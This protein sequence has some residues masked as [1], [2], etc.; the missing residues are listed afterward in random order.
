MRF[1]PS[2]A[3]PNEIYKFAEVYKSAIPPQFKSTIYLLPFLGNP[4]F[5]DMNLCLCNLQSFLRS[6]LLTVHSPKE[7]VKSMFDF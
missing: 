7:R 6:H 5:I 1:L 2:V 3:L 4:Q